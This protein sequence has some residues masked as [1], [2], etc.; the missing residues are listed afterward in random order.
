MAEAPPVKY[1]YTYGQKWTFLAWRDIPDNANPEVVYLRRFIFIKCPWFA[2]Y[3]HRIFLR[4]DDRYPH[5]HPFPF[6][7]FLL[8]GGYEEER[9]QP[10][11]MGIRALRSTTVRKRKR[12]SL[13]KTGLNDFHRIRVMHGKVRTLVFCGPRK[14]EWG[15]LTP[16]GF[17]SYAEVKG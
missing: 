6:W 1:G 3:F 2:I 5:N 14:Q 16:E 4:D 9:V 13:A 7:S 11:P 10:H 17:K 8:T 15:F 12:W